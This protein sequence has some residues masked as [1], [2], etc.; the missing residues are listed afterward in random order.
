MTKNIAAKFLEWLERKESSQNYIQENSLPEI[1]ALAVGL[2]NGNEETVGVSLD[3][4]L[5]RDLTMGEATG[6][7]LSIGLKMFLNKEIS[8]RGVVAPESNFID[9]KKLLMEIYRSFGME[10]AKIK[11]DK[12]W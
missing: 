5:T 4:T 12:S 8:L 9:H 11:I 2:K 10:D 6:N 7:P 3:G 1:Y